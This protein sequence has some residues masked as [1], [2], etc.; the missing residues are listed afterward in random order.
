[1]TAVPFFDLTAINGRVREDL[2]L[3][4]KSVLQHCKFVGGPEVAAFESEFAAYCGAD[5]CVGVANGTDA[6]ELIFAA[7]GIGAGDEV[8]VPANTFVATAEAVVAAGARPRFVD[9]LPDTL[10]IDPDSAAAAVNCRTAAIVGVHLFGQMVDVDGL[11]SITDRHGLALIED[12]AQAHGARFG[13]QRAGSVGAAAAFS[14]YPGKNL[15][16]LG[17]GGAVVSN[18]CELIGRVRCLANHGRSAVERHRHDERGRNSRLDSIQAAALAIKLGHL[19]E[20]NEAR[21]A[22]MRRYARQ[23]PSWCELVQTHRKAEPV[24]HLAVV[25]VPNRAVVGKSLTDAH[26][27][28]G[29]H[30]PI[31]CHRQP[32]YAEF[33][34]ELPVAEAAAEAVMSLPLSP[35]MRGEEIERVCDALARIQL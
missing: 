2:D 17:D 35:G 14:F 5:G 24:H 34:E 1:M 3:A 20:E 25:Q 30:Y 19:D 26:I 22:A 11:S 31:P 23:L 9:V 6:L 15:G 33:V 8:I 12:A 7:L 16:A 29:V 10:L 13:G 28:W 18:D 4:W 21:R 27:G 32:A